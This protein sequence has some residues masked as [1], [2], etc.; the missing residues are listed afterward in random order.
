M[1]RAEKRKTTS[2][3]T[4]GVTP[5]FTRQSVDRLETLLEACSF[6]D[7]PAG[8]KFLCK[9]ST[10]DLDRRV[11]K[12]GLKLEDKSLFAKLSSGDMMA[13]DA[14]YHVKCLGSLYNKARDTENF[15]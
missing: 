11:R 15:E 9:A 8:N 10:F 6:C 1:T 13:Q 5:K 12:C 3:D 4:E 7:K 14:L 2:G